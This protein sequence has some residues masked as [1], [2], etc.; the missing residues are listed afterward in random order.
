[1]M[2][3]SGS[4]SFVFWG[5]L[6]LCSADNPGIK[7]RF[8]E[9]GL[10]Y[11]VEYGMN[12][13]RSNKSETSLPDIKGNVAMGQD[14]MT[15]EFTEVRIV[16]FHFENISP[17]FV[18]GTGVQIA[19]Q[20]GNATI[21]SNFKLYGWLMSDS[22]SSVLTLTEISASVVIGVARSASNKTQVYLS[23]C[24]FD[25][26]GIDINMVGGVSYIYDAIK[27][28]MQKMIRNNLNEQLC[29]SV[30]ALIQRWDESLSQRQPNVSLND[31]V[32]LDVSLVSEPKISEKY[33]ELD[34]KG[35]FYS[36]L[37]GSETGLS[38]SPM[39]FD[40]KADSMI[41]A[42]MSESSLNSAS[43]AYYNGGAFTFHLS[44]AISSF[45][46]TTSQMAD[47]LPE[48]SQ[49]YPNPQKVR[50]LISASR[51]PHF[52]LKPDNLTVAFNGIIKAYV[53]VSKTRQET[54]FTANT[55]VSIS[56]NVSLSDYNHLP[57]F[58]FT[59]F[60]SLNS[61]QVQL[62]KSQSGTM[63]PKVENLKQGVYVPFNPVSNA[64]AIVNQG[65]LVLNTDV[66]LAHVYQ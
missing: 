14:K 25:I 20:D 8:T 40:A 9:K 43:Q 23:K 64:S 17:A 56:A 13:L 52:Y 34:L 15:Y 26:N 59:G 31:Y 5:L 33:A 4:I 45:K 27:E 57:G 50:V 18:P 22:G 11:G 66:I 48:L 24:Q 63:I 19:I 55:D 6:W 12:Y 46:L 10:K 65:F 38:S 39:S 28:P 53:P 30:K 36:K 21:K 1:M 47:I 41:N 35:M 16:N 44:N 58:N 60:I 3:W 2:Q 42:G 49:R 7:V 51:A 29:S 37:N 32:D 62:E 61:I 54:L